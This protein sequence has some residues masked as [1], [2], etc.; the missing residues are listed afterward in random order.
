M[1]WLLFGV[2]LPV[3]FEFGMDGWMDG[4]KLVRSPWEWKRT[5]HSESGPGPVRDSKATSQLSGSPHLYFDERLIGH[6]SKV[7]KTNLSA[8]ICGGIVLQTNEK[9]VC[10]GHWRTQVVTQS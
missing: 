5:E 8:G 10:V 6:C 4:L 2:S 7:T 1:G 9:R 3:E